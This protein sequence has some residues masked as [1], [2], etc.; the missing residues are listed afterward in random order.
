M[1]I[2]MNRNDTEL[3]VAVEGRL[4]T[5]TAPDLEEQLDDALEGVQKLIFDFENLEYISS[6]GLRVL[7]G[8][9]DAMMDQDGEMFV[10]GANEDVLA[11]FELTGFS[12]ELNL[13]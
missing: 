5:L 4:D 7:A 13:I 11:V 1:T 6:A 3:T 12:D 2:S 8:A 9:I 10:S